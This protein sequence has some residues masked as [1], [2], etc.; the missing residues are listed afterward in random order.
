MRV[1]VTGSSGMIGSA[2]VSTL[3]GFG[4]Q[5]HRLIRPGKDAQA[6]DVTWDPS[7]DVLAPEL[8]GVDAVVH[9]AGESITGRWTAAKKTA[10]ATS[11]IQGTRNLSE[12][13]AR[14][15]RKPS[16]LVAASAIGYY[17]D[18]G[19]EPLTEKSEPGDA[20][21]S[22]VA[23]AWEE[24]TQ[25]AA[26][27]GIRVVN[28]RIGMVLSSRGG[29]LAEMLT[30]FRL[31][32]GGPLGSGKQWMSWIALDDL[33]AAIR[34]I[35][36]REEL[37]GPVNAVSPGPVTNREFVRALGHVLHRPAI[38]PLPSFAIEA[39]FGEMGRELLLASARVLPKKLVD[40]GFEYQH[41]DLEAALEAELQPQ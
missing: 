36:D 1:A 15:D 7:T 27:A 12:G 38:L 16:V 31:G 37:K 28:I 5:I 19:D 33:I 13:F 23:K 26:N 20:F 14:L 17:G 8:A 39:L 2:L 34:F 35:F 40:A 21:L 24:A 18:R 3:T 29:A 22:T 4:H 30:P 11:R 9:L 6:P 32:V 10:I 25:P 41:P